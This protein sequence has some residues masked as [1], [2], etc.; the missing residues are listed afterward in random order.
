[1]SGVT[2]PNLTDH[3][4]CQYRCEDLLG[5]LPIDYVINNAAFVR[6]LSRYHSAQ[7]NATSHSKQHPGH[8]P[9]ASISLATFQKTLVSNVIGPTLVYQTFQRFLMKSARPVVANMSSG[10]GSIGMDLGASA[11]A[12]SVSKTALN[13][14]VSSRE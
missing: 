7:S 9:L 3:L 4:S 8:M 6:P 1:V 14:L 5:E 11:G 12:Y 10:A 13:M 2:L